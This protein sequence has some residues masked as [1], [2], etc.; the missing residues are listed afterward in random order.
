MTFGMT[1]MRTLR[2]DLVGWQ[3]SKVGRQLIDDLNGYS[4]GKKRVRNILPGLG[5]ICQFLC[6]G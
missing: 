2:V 4:C 1:T 6:I 5:L 3:M